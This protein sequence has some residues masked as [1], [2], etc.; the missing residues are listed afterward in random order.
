MTEP[1]TLHIVF[2]SSTPQFQY[3]MRQDGSIDAW[4]PLGWRGLLHRLLGRFSPW[5]MPKA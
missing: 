3:R 2:T 5:R 1:E 4:P